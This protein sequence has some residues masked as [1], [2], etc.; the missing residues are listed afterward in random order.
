MKEEV[1]YIKKA[2]N[3]IK[4]SLLAQIKFYIKIVVEQLHK[5]TNTKYSIK[6]SQYFQ[7]AILKQVSIQVDQ[8]Q[9][10]ASLLIFR[11]LVSL[12]SCQSIALGSV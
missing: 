3:T 12:I 7:D 6:H 8:I 10:F 2:V 4:H 1:K 11:F 5:Y 9:F